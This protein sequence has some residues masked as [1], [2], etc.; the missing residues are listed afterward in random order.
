VYKSPSLIRAAH[1]VGRLLDQLDYNAHYREAAVRYVLR[2]GMVDGCE[3]IEAEDIPACEVVLEESFPDVPRDDPAWDCEAATWTA[4]LRAEDFD[5][6]DDDLP[7][8][9]RPST[10][11]GYSDPDQAV[12]ID[13]PNEDGGYRDFPGPERDWDPEADESWA[14][15]AFVPTAADLA[16]MNARSDVTE[17]L[18]GYE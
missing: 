7:S 8:Q 3:H 15:E 10:T 1:A 17:P 16:E 6:P 12:E 18:Y 14:A 11:G 2:T 9:G 5:D 4:P 13:S